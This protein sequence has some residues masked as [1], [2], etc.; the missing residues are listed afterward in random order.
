MAQNDYSIINK[1]IYNS[2]TN[3]TVLEINENLLSNMTELDK[4][5]YFGKLIKSQAKSIK[6]N[7]HISL[8]ILSNISCPEIEN[9]LYA[10]LFANHITPE[11][12][13]S[14]F[15]QVEA[16]IIN[17]DSEVYKKHYETIIILLDEKIILNNIANPWRVDVELKSS[18]D[19]R[20]LN[21]I[22]LLKKLINNTN[23][24]VIINTIV[25]SEK[26]LNQIIDYKSKCQAYSYINQLNQHIFNFASENEQVVVLDT[27]VLLQN[28][29]V[30]SLRDE[31][32][33]M[34]ADFGFHDS[35]LCKFSIEITK[36][37]NVKLSG[38]KKCI[39]LDL[40]NTLWGGVVGEDGV[41]KIILGGYYEGIAYKKFQQV[42]KQLNSQGILLAINS[43]NDISNVTEVF[44]KHPDMILKLTDFSSIRANWSP[45]NK[46]IEEIS[47]ELNIGTDSF[48]FVDDSE[49]EC[50]IIKKYHPEVT[51]IHLSKDP[52]L[53]INELLDN[54]YFNKF[55]LT[56]E[57]HLRTE[58]Y[59]S[60]KSRKLLRAEFNNIEEYLNELN[61]K[62]RI[63][64]P[65]IFELE[66][67]AQLSMRTNQFNLTSRRYTAKELELLS[68]KN[69]WL[70]IGVESEDKF[71]SNGIIAAAITELEHNILFIRNLLLSCR[72][73]SRG[74]EVTILNYI[75]NYA[76]RNRLSGVIGEFIQTNKNMLAQNFYPSNG[77]SRIELPLQESQHFEHNLTSINPIP[78]WIT[79]LST[80]LEHQ[81]VK[82]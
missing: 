29:T 49:A 69:E 54:G 58:R 6:T 21:I 63:F 70:I 22:A 68:T 1:K 8:A 60:E 71:G 62:L 61:I 13:M 40:D 23:S 82:H 41:E 37:L 20:A 42:I 17:Q 25:L 43:K 36:I 73:F 79:M 31:R 66:R 18:I 15:N 46:N 35:L 48:V 74:I 51:V 19:S 12:Y 77:F 76:K 55:K 10:V 45:K 27:N 64:T 38:L 3:D 34:F 81:H 67:I 24:T 39:V 52:F 53:Y 28:H 5:S 4:L 47:Q 30:V 57:D 9:I 32:M 44:Q 33:A 16:D 65:T 2:L 78:A 11:I 72:V 59:H 26:F 50:E 14:N 7:R 56:A 75:L 80:A